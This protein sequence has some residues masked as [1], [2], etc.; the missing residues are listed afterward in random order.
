MNSRIFTGQ[1]MHAR[2]RPVQHR[3][4]YPVYFYG[5]DIDELEDLDREIPLFGHNRIRP[6]AIHDRDYLLPGEVSLREKVERVLDRFDGGGSPA[7]VDLVTSARYLHYVFNPVSFFYCYGE[8]GSLNN[9][10]V[11][12]TNTFGEM[13]V[14]LLKD[15]LEDSRGYLGHFRARKVFHVSPFFDRIGSYEFFLSDSR[16]DEL[17]IL[18]HY[19]QKSDLVFAARLR[20]S[21]RSLYKKN[22]N[23]TLCRHPVVAALTVPRIMW[24]AGR[25]HYQRRLPVYHKPPPASPGTIRPA[26]LSFVERLGRRMAHRHLRRIRNGQLTVLY[27]SGEGQTFG[28]PEGG[29]GRRASIRILDNRFYRRTLLRGEIGLGESYTAG[30][31]DSEDLPAFLALMAD[32]LGHVQ[33][34]RHRWS[35][36]GRTVDR[37]R[38]ALRPN[39]T[40]GSRNNISSHYDR[41][42]DFF[43]LFLDPTMTY[44]CALFEGP[45]DSLEEAQFN[46]IRSVIRKARIT[47]GDQV[48]E[49][50][51]GWGSLAIEAA[52]STGCSVTGITIS[53]KQL[54]FARE[55]VLRAGL[56]DRITLELLDYRHLEGSYDAVVSIEMLEAVGH[57][58]LGR[59]FSIV[60]RVLKH[61][62]RAVVQVITIPDERYRRY[63]RNPDWI[64]KHIFPGGHLPSMEAMTR[65]VERIPGL[66]IL[67][68]EDIGP[69]YAKTLALWREALLGNRKRILSMGYD[70]DFVRKWEYYFAYCEAG[71]STGALHD[72]QMVLEKTAGVAEH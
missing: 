43:A 70:E 5:L 9:V 34:H 3:F 60:Q 17:D 59:Y 47:P 10:V 64:R 57:G 51:V 40:R 46:K 62:G 71:F 2:S 63:R 31:W 48:L 38:H 16:R 1:V 42:N 30:E 65:A 11:Q 35:T 25:L 44:S 53:G 55:R 41:S 4:Q 66:D 32:N 24:Q 13:H 56:G 72:Y 8:D 37:I 6:V 23:R 28:S 52:R 7:R 61:G 14:Y 36:A 58:N 68:V 12:V 39:T 45:G 19:R 67:E 69:H 49:I 26:P 27:L 54:E 18:I 20:G 50:G 29:N 15:F 22:L 33:D 21:A